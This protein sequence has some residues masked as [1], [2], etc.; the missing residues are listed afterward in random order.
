MLHTRE[1]NPT[2]ADEGWL[3]ASH[4]HEM[5]GRGAS[6]TDDIMWDLLS[7]GST[8]C[9]EPSANEHVTVTHFFPKKLGTHTKI[10][11]LM[12]LACVLSPQKFEL[13]PLVEAQHHS[14]IQN[15]QA[16]AL[17]LQPSRHKH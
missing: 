12:L 1:T 5:N 16:Q 3:A 9:L 11:P 6:R 14:K 4:C 13:V 17:V 10:K 7:P 15:M 8:Q 2:K